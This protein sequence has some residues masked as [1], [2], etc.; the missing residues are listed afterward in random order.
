M[1]DEELIEVIDGFDVDFGAVV[2][3]DAQT[4]LPPLV[5]FNIEG[6]LA[7]HV[8]DVGAVY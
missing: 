3:R 5:P 2:R 1:I 7:C 4:R 8:E 6:A